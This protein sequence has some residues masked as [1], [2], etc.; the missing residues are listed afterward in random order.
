[1]A[2]GGMT[3]DTAAAET[4]RSIAPGWARWRAL[5]AD[6]FPAAVFFGWAAVFVA[7]L[8][9]NIQNRAFYLDSWAHMVFHF[10]L[11]A[12]LLGAVL[13]ALFLPVAVRLA[14]A[15]SLAS[16][17]PAIYGAELYLV[18]KR[19][20]NGRAIDA[21]ANFDA[22]DKLRVLNDLGRAG[23]P[24]F[25]V[26]YVR[27]LLRDNGN[28]EFVPALAGDV[29]LLPLAGMPDATLVVCNET[30]QWTIYNSDPHGFRNPPEAWSRTPRVVLV[31]DSFVHGHCVQSDQS[32]PAHLAR[33][34]GR[35]FNLGSGGH[36][37]LAELATLREYA[38]PLRPPVVLWVFYEG[39]DLTK[40]FAPEWRAPILRAYLDDPGFRQNLMTRR[41]EIALR[42]RRHLDEK[43][44]ETMARI[45]HPFELWR[46]I[47]QVYHLRKV[48]GLGVAA[49][50]VIEGDLDE[51][52]ARFARVLEAAA[53]SVRGWGGQSIFVYLPD[54]E[55]Y[56]GAIKNNPVRERIRRSVL[57]IARAANLPVVDLDSVLAAAPDPAGLYVFPGAHFNAEGYALVAAAIAEA[58]AVRLAVGARQAQSR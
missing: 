3:Q 57:E 1:M 45:D 42:V 2:D 7:L 16:A 14:V 26:T 46:D 51:N 13:A 19:F 34:F 58:P 35:V 12:S 54:G 20:G 30:G 23:Q 33:R 29:P 5:F 22:R 44:T 17:V 8:V 28:G 55:R 49:L 41:G 36:G 24:A 32:I 21:G 18:A 38:E 52:I 47:L 56:F 9:L 37:P 10:V 53:R 43:L 31:G 50:G 40:D 4:S 6:A 39:N 25:P 48:L 15:L 27:S 11:P